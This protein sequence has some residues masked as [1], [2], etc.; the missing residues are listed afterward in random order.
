MIVERP[1]VASTTS[2]KGMSG[3]GRTNEYAIF[4]R[5]RSRGKTPFQDAAILTP[6]ALDD[7]DFCHNGGFSRLREINLYSRR[8]LDW[9]VFPS[10]GKKTSGLNSWHKACRPQTR[11]IECSTRTKRGGRTDRLRKEMESQGGEGN[12][13]QW[14]LQMSNEDKRENT[15]EH[16]EKPHKPPEPPHHPPG[17]PNPPKPPKPREVG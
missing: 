13:K 15:P 6:V 7:S 11:I 8:H 16:P 17:P 2:H 14:R 10:I 12:L 3:Q 9:P 1:T 4:T 5:A